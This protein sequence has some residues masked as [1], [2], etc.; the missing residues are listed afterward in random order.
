MESSQTIKSSVDKRMIFST[1]WIFVTLNYLYCDVIGLMDPFLL[2][3]YLSGTISSIKIDENFLLGGAIL[4]EIPISMVLLSRILTFK[5]NRLA[6]I[7]AG[8]IKTLAMLAS[9]FV[10]TPSSYYMFFAGIE[11]LTTCFIVYY[12]WKWK[13]AADHVI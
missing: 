9:F 11:I 7:I 5:S 12:A 3:Q 1:L 8:T 2:N 4:M 6:N 10:G 13:E